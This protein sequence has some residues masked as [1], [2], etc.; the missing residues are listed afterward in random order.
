MSRREELLEKF[1]CFEDETAHRVEHGIE[2][3]RKGY[4]RLKL[5]DREGNLLPGVRIREKLRNH[6]FLHGANLFMLGQFESEEKNAKY[7]ELFSRC[8]NEATLPIYWRDLE[9][10][11]GKPRFSA[12][13]PAVYRRPPVDLC[14]DFC[15]KNRIFP[16][17]HCLTYLNFDPAW[18]DEYDIQSVR[19]RFDRR[20][21]ELA[22]KY[23]ERI[24]AWEV[25]NEVLCNKPGRESTPYFAD[26]RLVSDSFAAAEKYFPFNELIINEASHIWEPRVFFSY[27]RSAYYLL[28]EDALRKGCRIDA[29]G[30]QFHAFRKPDREASYTESLY[31]PE[32]IYR[33]LD[34]YSALGLPIQIT[35]IT[36]PAFYETKE[37]Y[38]LQAEIL[39]RLY[40]IWFSHPSVEAAI[41]WNLPDGYAAFAPR[42]DMS[43]GENIYRGGLLDYDLNPKPAYDALVDLFG[44]EW[45]TD[46]TV[47]TDGEGSAKFLGFFGD[48]EIS[49]GDTKTEIRLRK[50]ISRTFDL[51]V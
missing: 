47:E 11:D 6:A 49:I 18:L 21:R 40:R 34:C 31:N 13:S 45:T 41:Y 48:Y 4:C 46:V 5:R 1:I 39:R 28:I 32:Q 9:P 17:A 10:E 20:Y 51:T 12:D 44:N 50:G 36:I 24:P 43:A 23:A 2:L 14:L 25:V 8:F 19:R 42:G 30:M 26:D 16:K 3:Y 37:D 27:K 7:D 38:E 33:V 22:E 29:V 35:E 15:E